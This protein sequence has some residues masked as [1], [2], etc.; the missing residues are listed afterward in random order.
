MGEFQVYAG[1]FPLSAL[2]LLL[3]KARHTAHIMHRTLRWIE[4]SEVTGDEGRDRS[5]TW[6]GLGSTGNSWLSFNKYSLA[7]YPGPGFMVLT[8]S[9]ECRD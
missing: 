5:V 6:V 8:H 2:V 7:I 3:H 4:L 1:T 9:M